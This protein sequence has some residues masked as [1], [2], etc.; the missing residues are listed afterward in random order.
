ME[1]LEETFERERKYV[2]IEPKGG[3][4]LFYE[5]IY[6]SL[7][8]DTQ[9]KDTK[10]A[11]KSILGFVGFNYIPGASVYTFY[12]MS[13]RKNTGLLVGITFEIAKGVFYNGLS[14]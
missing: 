13:D 8:T 11:V 2:P 6:D 1:K 12:R 9:S 7:F 4:E 3:L 5:R 10:K 14:H